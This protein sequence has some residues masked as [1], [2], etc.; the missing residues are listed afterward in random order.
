M[1]LGRIWV[2]RGSNLWAGFPVIEA[3]I[4]LGDRAGDRPLV[5]G[6]SL[7]Q[8]LRDWPGPLDLGRLGPE[9]NLADLLLALTHAWQRLIDSTPVFGLVHRTSRPGFY[10]VVF[11]YDEEARQGV[12][13][14]R[15][16]FPGRRRQQAAV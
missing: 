12:P 3:E 11:E 1:E 6:G 13:A 14:G 8:R 7:P 4:D 2:L 10:R 15:S 5:E 9:A 16:R